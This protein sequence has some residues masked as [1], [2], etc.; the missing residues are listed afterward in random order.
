MTTNTRQT[1]LDLARNPES[2][3]Y[4]KYVPHLEYE[5]VSIPRRGASHRCAFWDGYIGTKNVGLGRGTIAYE[6]WLAGK[7]F[8]KEC[9]LKAEFD[10]RGYPTRNCDNFLALKDVAA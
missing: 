2:E 9:D 7:D 3:L 1:M 6:C 5:Y 10:W 4:T 8:A